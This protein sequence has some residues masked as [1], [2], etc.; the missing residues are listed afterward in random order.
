MTF[1]R[2]FIKEMI[3]YTRSSVKLYGKDVHKYK[4]ELGI[5]AQIELLIKAVGRNQCLWNLEVS[6]LTFSGGCK[7]P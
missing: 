2:K 5:T 6:S 1:Q 7:D 4:R 3:Y